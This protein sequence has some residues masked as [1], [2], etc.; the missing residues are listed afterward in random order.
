[1]KIKLKR[2]ESNTRHLDRFYLARKIIRKCTKITFK[3]LY[4][5]YFLI[6]LPTHVSEISAF[7]NRKD[8]LIKDLYP[9]ETFHMPQYLDINGN[10]HRRFNPYKAKVPKMHIVTITKGKTIIGHTESYTNDN[11]VIKEI[12]DNPDKENRKLGKKISELNLNNPQII[13]GSVALISIGGLG[14]NYYHFWV[15]C[16]ARYH[17]L[18]TSGIKPDYYIFPNKTKIHK[19][20]IKLSKIK[21][22]KIIQLKEN[23]VICADKLIVPSFINNYESIKTKKY[24]NYCIPNKLSQPVKQW[25]PSWLSEFYT[26]FQNPLAKPIHRIYISRRKACRKILNEDPLI[27]MLNKYNFKTLF[28][29]DLSLMEQINFF[30]HASIIIA[31][32]GAG[33]TNISFSKKGTIILELYPQYYHD[34]CF[35]LHATLLGHDYNYL[36]GCAK[37]AIKKNQSKGK[38][39]KLIRLDFSVDV[40]IIEKFL[41]DNMQKIIDRETDRIELTKTR[42]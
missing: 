20:F 21:P 22:E 19:Q 23:T 9:Q 7:S 15:E 39:E 35:R 34:P 26:N 2:P 6:H 40:N 33:L 28:L 29:E 42:S 31:P 12:R 30:N 16:L 25:L 11:K 27:E 38:K 36:I 32:H 4:R 37:E 13:K 24:A 17:L 3:K 41:Q 5:H 18:N 1:M 8:I 14:D 10:H